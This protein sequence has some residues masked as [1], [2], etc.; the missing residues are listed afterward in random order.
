MPPKL[1]PD[2]K[3]NPKAQLNSKT[4]PKQQILSMNKQ[5]IPQ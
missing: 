3:K 1:I 4:D 2:L 5:P